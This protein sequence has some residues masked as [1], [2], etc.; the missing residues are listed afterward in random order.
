MIPDIPIHPVPDDDAGLPP[1]SYAL[2]AMLDEAC[3]RPCWPTSATEAGNFR[4]N[5]ERYMFLMGARSLVDE[6]VAQVATEIEADGD[7]GARD[8]AEPEYPQILGPD[9]SVRDFLSS[10]RVAA[11]RVG[12]K[13]SLR[14]QDD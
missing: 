5:V 2:I 1:R 4:A 13:L 12:Q 14:D 10:V 9:G 7:E 11:E 3:A 6:L 8:E